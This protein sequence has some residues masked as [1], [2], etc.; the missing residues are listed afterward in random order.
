MLA[1]RAV[2]QLEHRVERGGSVAQQRDTIAARHVGR[3]DAP[4]T[5]RER[6][7]RDGGHIRTAAG[8]IEDRE[9]GVSRRSDL[10]DACLTRV[11]RA[12]SGELD[13]RVGGPESDETARAALS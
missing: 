12:G 7:T 10:Q 3:G 13:K 6:R 2:D 5:A 4:K 11:R 8:W 9:P 1:L